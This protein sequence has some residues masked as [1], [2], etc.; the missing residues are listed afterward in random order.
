MRYIGNLITT[1]DYKL[2]DSITPNGSNTTF[3][4][5]FGSA[6]HVA[7]TAA[8]LLVYVNGVAQ[9][10]STDYSLS[11]NGSQII[12][13]TAPASSD[14]IFMVSMY[15]GSGTDAGNYTK[16]FQASSSTFASSLSAPS[17]SISGTSTLTGN[18]AAQDD[19]TVAGD[20]TVTGTIAQSS[21]IHLKTN[22]E[23][24][25]LSLDVLDKLRGVTYTRTDTGQYESGLIAEEV[26]KILPYLTRGNGSDKMLMYTRLIAF[27]VEGIKELR[28]EVNKLKQ[29]L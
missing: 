10:P 19:I 7:T 24:I 16:V 20:M 4:L 28:Q 18:V 29:K 13:S 11:A 9:K 23:P 1:S 25:T 12:F 17:L 26:E 14:S 3:N 5:L 21:S 27:L 22:V 2:L 15:T 6:S 8:Q